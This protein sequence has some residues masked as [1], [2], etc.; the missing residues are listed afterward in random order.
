[1][2]GLFQRLAQFAH[3]AAQVEARQ[4]N[5]TLIG[6][7]TGVD[8]AVQD[9][10]FEPLL[11]V[12]AERGF[13]R[14]RSRRRTPNR[15]Q[16]AR[17]PRDVGSLA[18]RQHAHSVGTRR[19]SRPGLRGDRGERP[20]PWPDH[21]RCGPSID[22]LNALIFQPGFSTR[23]AA[24]AIAG[25]GVGMDVV[26]QEVG[27]LHGTVEL[28]SQPGEGTRLS[29][30]LPARLSLQQAMVLRVD[31]RA[32]ALPVEIVEL[33][34]PFDSAGLEPGGGEPRAFSSRINGFLW[35]RRATL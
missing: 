23:E 34:Q 5:V 11:H 1:M 27:R 8:R 20:P 25:R 26:S 17:R 21:R 35:C 2:R 22:R 32:L 24:N 18:D 33:A 3:D 6:D 14:H 29:L 7:E 31:G 13:P 12:G 15:G 9:K 4:V 30:R 16:T 19:R 28:E 10:A